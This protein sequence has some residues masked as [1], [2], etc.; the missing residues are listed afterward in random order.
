MTETIEIPPLP[1]N[2]ILMVEVGSTA[3][4]TGID[5]GE[6]HDQ[7]AVVVETPEQ[8]MGLDEQG[9][10]TVMQRTQPEGVRSGPGDTDRT[11][12]SLRRFLRLAASGNPSILMTLWAPVE[13]ATPEGHELQGLGEAFIG[14]HVVPRYRGYM[15]SQVKR[16]LGEGGGG[17]GVR[18]SGGRPEL[19]EEF[20][21]DTKYAMHAA[22]LGFQCI[23]LL[24]TGAL[25]LPITSP[26]GD[27]LRD[28]RY[29][30]V[31]FDEWFER[32]VELDAALESLLDDESVPPGPDRKQIEAWSVATHHAIWNKIN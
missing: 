6:D 8:V 28:V 16:L 9:F 7:L 24:S 2:A 18:G 10:K 22:R 30:R 15:Q 25:Q 11:L 17:H 32:T 29:G 23:E 31:E 4:G 1:D 12:H 20:G 14:R 5:G 13:F 27:W 21:Y 3:H 26:D 19:I